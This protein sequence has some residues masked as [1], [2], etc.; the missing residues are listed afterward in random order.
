MSTTHAETEVS[1]QIGPSRSPVVAALLIAT[2]IAIVGFVVTF[3]NDSIETVIVRASEVEHFDSPQD[4]ASRSDLVVVGTV[5]GIEPSRVISGEVA[6]QLVNVSVEVESVLAGRAPD[7]VSFQWEPG[8]IDDNGNLTRRYLREGV[9]APQ[10]GETYVLFLK[11]FPSD[12]AAREPNPSTHYLPT[13][14]GIL[15]VDGTTVRSRVD[16]DAALGHRIADLGIEGITDITD[17]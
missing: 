12:H 8:E 13:V 11:E 1:P 6:T 3:G 17:R 10:I 2:A 14:N 7:H 15:E 16:Q 5:T 9:P 4:L